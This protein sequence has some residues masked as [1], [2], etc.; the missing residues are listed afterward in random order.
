MTITVAPSAHAASSPRRAELRDLE[1]RLASGAERPVHERALL[2]RDA[3]YIALDL[4]DAAA[5]MAHALACLDLARASGDLP[6]QVKA[7]VALGLVQAES[8][9][10][11][12]ATNRFELADRLARDAGDDRGVALVAVNASH[13]ELE[14][15]QY[16]QALRLLLDLRHSPHARGLTLPES[17]SLNEIYHVNLVVSASEALLAGALHGDV[18]DEARAILTESVRTLEALAAR[19][20]A[21]TKPVEA[22]GVLDALMRAALWDGH[23]SRALQLADEHVTLTAG[24]DL[25]L[26]HGRALLER[27]RVRERLGD[28]DGAIADA[29]RSSAQFAQSGSGLWEARAREALAGTY[30]RAGQFQQAFEAQ[31]AVTRGVEK[32]YRDYHQQRA[33]VGQVEQQVR[34][35]EVRAE[36]LAEAALRDPLTGAPNRT[37]AMHVLAQLHERALAGQPS[38]IALMDL[39]L[40]KRVNDTYGHLVGDAVLTRVTRLLSAELRDI[41]LLARLGGEE[42]LVA[43]RDVDLHEARRIC[44]RLR[45]TLRGADWADTAPQLHTTGSFGLAALDGAHD[46]TGTLREADRALYRAKAAGRDTVV[47]AG[48]VST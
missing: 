34:E 41:D 25:P 31:Q 17:V 29:T 14:R 32:L 35:A 23:L 26:L 45:D 20:E 7:H 12:G 21:P 43:L 39:D 37:R 13:Y 30:A 1:A 9:D 8:Y 36:A 19:P 11:L 18:Q 24:V 47:V 3:V 4:G 6:L 5:A 27:S 10:D 48:E 46:V 33:L 40:F 22:S 15:R 2:H 28:L 44:E 42:F 16:A 38:A